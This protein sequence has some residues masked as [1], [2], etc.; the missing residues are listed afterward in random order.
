MTSRGD[1]VI[2]IDLLDPQGRNPK[3]RPC[4]IVSSP[5]RIAAGGPLEVVAIT[6]SPSPDPLP[7][8]HVRLPWQVPGETRCRT[9]LDK[10]NAAICSWLVEIELS[11]IARIIGHVPI[12]PMFKIN[13]ALLRLRGEQ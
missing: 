2:V 10:P 11:R 7:F 8:D 9:G 6:T 5:E 1:I 4:V 12:K 13:A 3:D